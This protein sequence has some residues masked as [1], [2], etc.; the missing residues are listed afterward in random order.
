M[1]NPAEHIEFKEVT[2]VEFIQQF[3]VAE[4]KYLDAIDASQLTR[5]EAESWAKSLGATIL[6]LRRAKYVQGYAA[7]RPR[8]P[9]DGND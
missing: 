2:C 4:W 6:V 9:E 8:L 1:F 3:P 5:A 7:L